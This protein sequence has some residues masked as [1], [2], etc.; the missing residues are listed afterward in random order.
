MRERISAAEQRPMID[1]DWRQLNKSFFDVL[2][3]EANVMFAILTLIV[4]VAALNIVSGLIM[5]VK[6]KASAIAVLRTMGAT[7]GAIQRIF[8]IAGATIGVAGTACGLALG[9]LVARNVE[10]IR[11]AL[12]WLTG[13]NLFPSEFYFLSQLPSRVE[14]RDVVA[15]ALMALALSLA[16]TIYPSW[17]AARLDPVEAL[18]YE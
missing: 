1:T 18:R 11:Q 17:R 16:A 3:V 12:S 5:L 6:D 4:L 2:T 13:L 9:L 7:R 15:V 14:A 8:L 10:E